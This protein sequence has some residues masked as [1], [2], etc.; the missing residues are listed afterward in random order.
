MSAFS[1]SP[2]VRA[3]RTVSG[4]ALAAAA[5]GL[6][7]V[8]AEAGAPVE[9]KPVNFG[10]GAGGAHAATHDLDILDNWMGRANQRGIRLNC[11]VRV[12]S[13]LP[14][15]GRLAVV[16]LDTTAA[17]RA[18][19]ALCRAHGSG[20]PE[21][22]T[23]SPGVLSPATLRWEHWGGGHVWLRI[24]DGA[25]PTNIA[26]TVNLSPGGQAAASVEV[27]LHDSWV[28]IPP[29]TRR[30][31]PYTW[32]PDPRVLDTPEWLLGLISAQAPAPR[33]TR[34]AVAVSEEREEWDASTP[35]AEI[36]PEAGYTRN[37]DDRMRD[38]GC[39]TWNRPG[40]ANPRS[41]IAHEGCRHGFL[42]QL[43]TDNRGDDPILRA[44]GELG[45]AQVTK[46]EA[47]AALRYSGDPGGIQEKVHKVLDAEELRREWDALS[48]DP[49]TRSWGSGAPGVEEKPG[50]PTRF[51]RL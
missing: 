48:L 42:L 12:G 15:G 14:G 44:A 3:D 17:L 49:L 22:T 25:L 32:G 2:L 30:E 38:C 9:K 37:G 1:L 19:A 13:H 34:G 39:E 47:L 40:Y 50:P 29:S 46:V 11:G 31:G 18:F 41:A 35:W 7:V 16:D 4:A 43:L 5:L 27:K 26:G 24:P 21:L 28:M 36:L 51:G 8:L 20:T 45:R 10:S 33:A 23:H 6:D